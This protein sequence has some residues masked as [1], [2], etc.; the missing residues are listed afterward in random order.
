MKRLLTGTIV[1]SLILCGTADAQ[2]PGNLKKEVEKAVKGTLGQDSEE[3]DKPQAGQKPG[4]RP[5]ANK[6][7][8]RKYPPGLSFSSLLN[9]VKLLPKNGKFSLHH[10]QTTFVP[11][12]CTEGFVVLRT[13]DGKELF[14]WDWKP[15]RL[16]TPYALIN[17][18]KRT[19]LQTGQQQSAGFIELTTPGDYVLDFYLPDEHF[20]TFP[21]SVVKLAGDDPFSSGDCYLLDGDW[22]DWGYMYYRDAKPDQSLHWK[23][24]LRNKSAEP[25]DAKI[26]VEV[27]RAAD[28][29]LVCTSRGAV[30]NRLTPDWVRYDFDLIFP[31]ELTSG[32][33]YFKAKDLLETDG[34]YTLTTKINDEVYGVW[35][36]SVEGGKLQYAGR[37]LRGEADPLTFIEG[38]KDAWWYAR[39]AK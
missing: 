2:F 31:Q 8:S 36:F 15:D 21:F 17:V 16:Q 13:A 18:H 33:Q 12:D 29:E 4:S 37:T 39:V 28:G 23:V 38:G 20:Y 34:D 3:S 7:K 26:L 25:L 27:T 6:D 24:W 10:I 14:Q 35:K 9:G 22:E 5:P 1:L 19:D 11:D 32:G 30:S